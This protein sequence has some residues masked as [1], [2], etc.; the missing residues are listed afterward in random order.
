MV[1]FKINGKVLKS[2]TEI[3]MSQ[4]IL[5]KTERTINGTMVVDIIGTKRKVDASWDYLSKED[6]ATLKQATSG[7]TFAAISFY[8]NTTSTM[9]TMD[10]RT[11]GVTCQPHYDWSKGKIM[12]K[13]VTV[14]F[15]EK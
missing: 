13:S 2:P 14:S 12:W 3:A 5:D 11:D 4:E 9:V 8:D 6:M 15:R 10:A 1:F 7:N